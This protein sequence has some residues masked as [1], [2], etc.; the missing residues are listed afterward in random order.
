MMSG[1]TKLNIAKITE[2]L[3]AHKKKI[4]LN[5]VEVDGVET[6]MSMTRQQISM[7]SDRERALYAFEFNKYAFNLKMQENRYLALLNWLEATLSKLTAEEAHKYFDKPGFI[8]FADQK[9]MVAVNN[10]FG[11]VLKKH[12]REYQLYLDDIRDTYRSIE[13]LSRALK[14]IK[15]EK[16]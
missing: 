16:R 4:G 7:L 12:I 9:E 1:G 13:Y 8:K 14:E 3:D 2:Q 11:R 10:D 5:Q 15:D 6:V